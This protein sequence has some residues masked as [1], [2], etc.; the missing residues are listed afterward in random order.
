LFDEIAPSD[1]LVVLDKGR[2]LARGQVA[3]VVSDAGAP[4][5][6]TAFMRLTANVADLG[7]AA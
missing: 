2:I 4:D 6:N 7:S 1:A 5:L 3:R